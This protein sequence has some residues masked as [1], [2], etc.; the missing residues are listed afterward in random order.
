MI[1]PDILGM[2]KNL[3]PQI[4]DNKKDIKDDKKGLCEFAIR[5]DSDFVIKCLKLVLGEE[6]QGSTFSGY[7]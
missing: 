7:D 2:A 5:G 1:L 6:I 3:I 4:L